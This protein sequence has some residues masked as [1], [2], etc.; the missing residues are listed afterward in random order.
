MIVE[1]AMKRKIR[2]DDKDGIRHYSF[3][4]IYFGDINCLIWFSKYHFRK[5]CS[6]ILKLNKK[7]LRRQSIEVYRAIISPLSRSQP[8]QRKLSIREEGD[9]SMSLFSAYSG[10]LALQLSGGMC[11]WD[12]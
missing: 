12:I 10:E 11:I 5:V 2:R 3:L 1:V 9:S 4:L 8:M 7:T 6:F